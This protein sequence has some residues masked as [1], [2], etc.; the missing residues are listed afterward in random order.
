M[1]MP[2]VILNNLDIIIEF[3]LSLRWLW[4]IVLICSYKI[5][6]KFINTIAR[7]IS[8]KSDVIIRD[9]K[10]NEE[11]IIKHLDYIINEALDEY[12]LLHIAPKQIYYINSKTEKEVIEYLSNEIPKRLS[13]VLMTHLS[14]IYNESYIGE[15]IGTHIY[16]TV[17][18][19]TLNFNLR[20][21]ATN[22]AM[23]EQNNLE[24]NETG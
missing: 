17:L 19:W 4:I 14:F 21:S 9:T 20:D 7:Y 11:E 12:N 15:F 3:V 22:N 10:Y 18:D 8:L 16:M 23:R 2:R 5:C 1:T 6:K 24:L 13:K